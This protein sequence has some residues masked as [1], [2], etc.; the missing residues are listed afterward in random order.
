MVSKYQVSN[1]LV[2]YRPSLM[3]CRKAQ[4][5]SQCEDEHI[6]RHIIYAYTHRHV[7]MYMYKYINIDI[8]TQTCTC[9]CTCI[10]VC[11]FYSDLASLDWEM[12][13]KQPA[14]KQTHTD[15]HTLNKYRQKHAHTCTYLNPLHTKDL[16]LTSGVKFL[17]L[18]KHL[19]VWYSVDK[20]ICDNRWEKVYVHI[21]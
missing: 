20:N 16:N 21:I 7:H 3:N 14:Y 15:K 18:V 6:H 2:S 17:Q 5:R 12:R 19:S 13:Q 1:T 11:C 8:H 4:L 10:H 9:T